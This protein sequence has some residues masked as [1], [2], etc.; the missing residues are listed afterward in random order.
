MKAIA[1]VLFLAAASAA[2]QWI[3]VPKVKYLTEVS[4]TKTNVELDQ[5]T[6]PCE[7]D[8]WCVGVIYQESTKTCKIHAHFSGNPV[9]DITWTIYVPGDRTTVL[10]GIY[11]WVTFVASLPQQNNQVDCVNLCYQTANCEWA[12]YH[13]LSRVCLAKKNDGGY[14]IEIDYTWGRPA[15][16][17]GSSNNDYVYDHVYDDFYD[18]F[19]DFVSNYIYNNIQYFYEYNNYVY[20]FDLHLIN[21]K[22][23]TNNIYGNIHNYFHFFNFINFNDVH[24]V[25]N[26]Y[27]S[28]NSDNIC[29]I[30]SNSQHVN[31]YHSTNIERA[32][33]FNQRFQYKSI[34]PTD[35]CADLKAAF[36]SVD[37]QFDCTN[38]S[39]NGKYVVPGLKKVLNQRG[40]RRVDQGKYVLFEG[41]RVVHVVFPRMG[42]AQEV[43]KSIGSFAAL[44][45]I[46]LSGNNLAGAI[47][48]QIGALLSLTTINLSG[49][50]IS[51]GIPSQIGQLKGLQLIELSQN[52]LVGSIPTQLAQLPNIKALSLAG[53]QLTGVIPQI[54]LQNIAKKGASVSFGTNCLIGQ[55]NQRSNC[56]SKSPDCRAISLDSGYL[57]TRWNRLW[58][59]LNN[60]NEDMNAFD[61]AVNEMGYS[62]F[63]VHEYEFQAFRYYAIRRKWCKANNPSFFNN[64]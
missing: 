14:E 36:P 28:D 29:I 30:L 20:Y 6:E 5:C 25:F 34:K 58:T 63:G 17:Q 39:P 50:Q 8:P 55:S 45:I 37:Y 22:H 21:Y 23:F 27:Y 62:Y 38:I 57:D 61:K 42:L 47:P 46:D 49:N 7:K 9:I 24:H 18:D 11:P 43:P 51:G 2:L 41:Y 64:V 32:S 56:R 33:F 13:P 48:T 35:E 4:S 40:E 60:V 12:V 59:A 53:N 52:Q 16:Y 44:Q 10:N 54:L 15:D 19:N 31:W 26:F 3:P 1:S